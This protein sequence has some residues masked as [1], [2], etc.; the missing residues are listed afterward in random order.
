MRP[1]RT[2]AD[3]L[4][5]RARHSAGNILLALSTSALLR[6]CHPLVL[7]PYDVCSIEQLADCQGAAA[8]LGVPV[9]S[10]LHR[11]RSNQQGQESVDQPGKGSI[12]NVLVK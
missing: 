3:P 1:M 2:L 7:L 11:R 8:G 4:P 9:E 6:V 10:V 12:W 5:S